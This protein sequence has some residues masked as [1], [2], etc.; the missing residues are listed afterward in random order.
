MQ[1]KLLGLKLL[2]GAT[3]QLLILRDI[4]PKWGQY[5]KN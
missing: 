1:F 2:F 5:Y 4:V 3:P